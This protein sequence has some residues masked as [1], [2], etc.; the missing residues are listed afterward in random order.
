MK[1]DVIDYLSRCMEC[2]KVN[3]EHR[4][5]AGLLQPFPILEWKWEF[6]TI[7]FITKFPRKTRQHDS[8][9]VVVEKLTDTAHFIH[10][11]ITHKETNITKNYM[12]EISRLHGVPKTIVSD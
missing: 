1:R 3:V 7:D 9:M 12:R 8:I 6:V 2:Q 5:P 4:H 10:V 11:K